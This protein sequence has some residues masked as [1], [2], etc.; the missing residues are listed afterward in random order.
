MFGGETSLI[1]LLCNQCGATLDYDI[2]KPCVRCS[3]CGTITYYDNVSSQELVNAQREIDK[4]KQR[5][6]SARVAHDFETQIFCINMLSKMEPEN[7]EYAFYQKLWRALRG[8]D[9]LTTRLMQNIDDALLKDVQELLRAL[10]EQGTVYGKPVCLL[11]VSRYV[12]N[13]AQEMEDPEE[14][15]DGTVHHGHKHVTNTDGSISCIANHRKRFTMSFVG[16]TTLAVQLLSMLFGFLIGGTVHTAFYWGSIAG[17]VCLVILLCIRGSG[18]ASALLTC[19]VE[20][21]SKAS[22]RLYLYQDGVVLE[23]NIGMIWYP[24][25]SFPLDAMRKVEL[26]DGETLH[27]CMRSHGKDTMF[28]VTN[29]DIGGILQTLQIQGASGTQLLANYINMRLWARKGQRN[30]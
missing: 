15:P 14:N 7:A 30:G 24:K 5:L 8:K 9:I 26:V 20:T 21:P 12:K 22:G 1:S 11:A 10:S 23:N 13:M 27:F 2:H 19:A 4:L 3:H 6:R 29:D 17:I 28:H 18:Q 25:A 16:I